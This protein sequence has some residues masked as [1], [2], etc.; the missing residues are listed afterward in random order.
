MYRPPSRSESFLYEKGSYFDLTTLPESP[1][2]VL[3]PVKLLSSPDPPDPPDPPKIIQPLHFLYP[4]LFH[5]TLISLFESIFFFT[6]VST[7]EDKGILSTIQE[8]VNPLLQGCWNWTSEDKVLALD[9]LNTVLNV[10][11]LEQEAIIATQYREDF[12][13][14]LFVRSWIYVGGL[15]STTILLTAILLW[16]K[17]PPNWKKL[18]TEQLT[19]VLLL[20]LY[21]WIFF[22]TIVLPYKAISAVEV[23]QYV[24]NELNSICNLE[25]LQ[26]SK[27]V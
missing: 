4:F 12:N 5:I 9:I 23:N 17:S 19:M 7:L 22:R 1:V 2:R 21:E 18:L 25:G 14:T 20:G 15:A 6:Y 16:N 27:D 8:Y 13:H 24:V 10:S 11:T 3:S 26:D